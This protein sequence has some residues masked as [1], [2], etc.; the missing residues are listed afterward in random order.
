MSEGSRR[1]IGGLTLASVLLLSAAAILVWHSQASSMSPSPEKAYFYDLE[2]DTLFAAPI[3]EVAPI[4]GPS[5]KTTQQGEG[6][7]VLA[8]VFSCGSCG[9][10][11][12]RFVGYLETTSPGTKAALGAGGARRPPS[13]GRDLAQAR[14]IASVEDT[15]QWY[16]AAD[17]QAVKIVDDAL[18][19]CGSGGKLLTCTPK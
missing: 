9:R 2:G 4:V 16:P 13:M 15:T 8:R 12:D 1:K 18:A 14:M 11:A 7:A 5:G 10:E 19:R 3:T 17:P 6:T